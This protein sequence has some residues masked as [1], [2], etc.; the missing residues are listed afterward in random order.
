M[1]DSNRPTNA[2]LDDIQDDDPFAE[3]TRIMGHDPRTDGAKGAAAGSTESGNDD[4]EIDLEGELMGDLSSFDEEENA[5]QDEAAAFG[6]VFANDEER[7][8]ADASA[9]E[10]VDEALSDLDLEMDFDAAFADTQDAEAPWPPRDDQTP[11]HSTEDE[12]G[13]V[14]NHDD[15]AR[16]LD[17]FGEDAVAPNVDAVNTDAVSADAPAPEAGDPDIWASQEEGPAFLRNTTPMTDPVDDELATGSDDDAFATDLDED[18]QRELSGEDFSAVDDRAPA[19]EQP[20]DPEADI[21]MLEALEELVATEADDRGNDMPP[22]PP[23]GALADDE[24]WT[25]IASEPVPAEPY[26]TAPDAEPRA[27]S[28]DAELVEDTV[29][30]DVSDDHFPPLYAQEQPE[31]EPED[32]S[33]PE[34]TDFQAEQAEAFDYSRAAADRH[35]FLVETIEEESPAATDE[36][37]PEMIEPADDAALS[38][39]PQDVGTDA[40]ADEAEAPI[41]QADGDIAPSLQEALARLDGKEWGE[42]DARPSAALDAGEPETDSP[43]AGMPEMADQPADEPTYAQPV[44]ET[45]A[46]YDP[47]P[48]APEDDAGHQ[49]DPLGV[50]AGDGARPM[51]TPSTMAPAATMAA[52][53]ASYSRADAHEDD[54]AHDI[55]YGT[56]DGMQDDRVVAA[57]PA[58]ASAV[59]EIET[60]D[61]A[62]KP[63]ALDDD[64]DIPDIK[65]EDDAPT[66]LEFD[67]FEAELAGAFGSLATQPDTGEDEEEASP[68]EVSSQQADEQPAVAAQAPDVGAETGMAAATGTFAQE[69]AETPRYEA[70]EPMGAGSV[71][72]GLDAEYAG[73]VGRESSDLYYDPGAAEDIA[74]EDMAYGRENAGGGSRRRGILVAS[75]VA[76]VAVIGGIGAFALSSGDDGSSSPAVVRAGDDPVRV[77]P[78]NPGGAK[79]PNQ[80][81]EVYQRVAGKEAQEPAQEKLVSSTEEPV[82][83]TGPEPRV[84]TAQSVTEGGTDGSAGAKSEERLAPNGAED[85]SAIGDQVARVQARRVKTV[86]VKPDGTIV[87]ATENAASAGGE[88]AT[89]ASSAPASGNLTGAATTDAALAA[90]GMDGLADGQASSLGTASDDRAGGS[91]AATPAEEPETASEEAQV[92]STGSESEPAATASEAAA[93]QPGAPTS[94][95]SVQIS[96]QPSV[97]AAQQSYQN[98]SGRYGD[99]LSGQ[100]VNIVRADIDG[101]GTYYRVRIPSDSKDGAIELCSKLKSAGGSCFVT[102]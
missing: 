78:E 49:G 79:V 72:S 10:N 51:S 96:S 6:N 52:L 57:T 14:A 42:G 71:A 34:M 101:K 32:R 33:N 4:L 60:V 35:D 48:Q 28:A 93:P 80:D 15:D 54:V 59:P 50:F 36:T 74:A 37:R 45:E 3:L 87:S 46:V 12:G 88:S 13:A 58:A 100:G 77:K 40:V 21:G 83:V 81:S 20:N 22:A 67:D 85:D 27:T 75:L 7:P 56:H 102:K 64:L 95:W 68:Q 44:H 1:A 18:L 98:M 65:S 5:P 29:A 82:D 19:T 41:A 63:T 97:K 90:A 84:V 94:E 39:E 31:M 23:E 70:D 99:I 11:R 9:D 43:D 89:G 66:A 16:A 62:D 53:Q 76:I 8:A 2:H 73:A 25:D 47:E 91:D 69:F 92:A 30:D 24:G 38:L 55:D 17:P 26:A 86:V 61:I